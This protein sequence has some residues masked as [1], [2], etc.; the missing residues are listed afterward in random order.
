MGLKVTPAKAT[1][2]WATASSLSHIAGF[3]R[4]GRKSPPFARVYG[5]GE[6]DIR[7]FDV[8]SAG[9]YTFIPTKVDFNLTN[10]DGT[11]VPRDPTNAALGDVQIPLPVYRLSS[12]GGDT[13]FT[14]NVEYRIP[15]VNQVTF[16]FF[17]DFGM[18]FDTQSSQ[19]RKQSDDLAFPP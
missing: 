6:N 12:I 9:P 8:R 3:W 5:G 11:G 2:S 15:I 14:A 7:G 1:T 18:T 17:T 16:A 13:S 19:L 10:P 4:T